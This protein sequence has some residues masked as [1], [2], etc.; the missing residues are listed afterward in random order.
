MSRTINAIL[1]KDM[2]RCKRRKAVDDCACN[3]MKTAQRHR[4]DLSARSTGTV[5]KTRPSHH[6][7][8][9]ECGAVGD[10]ALVN[11][12]GWQCYASD[13]RLLSERGNH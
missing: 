13:I 4:K 9:A 6:L 7:D 3:E 2:V 10:S 11:K 8:H 12:V 1:R 5:A